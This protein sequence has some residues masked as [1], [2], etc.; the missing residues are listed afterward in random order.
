MVEGW[1]A[2]S[3]SQVPS[4]EVVFVPAAP[5]RISELLATVGE[6]PTGALVT[7]TDSDVVIDG[8]LP[9]EQAD[10]VE[11]RAEVVIDESALGINASGVVSSVAGRPGTDRSRRFSRL[12]RGRCEGPTTIPHRRLGAVDG[13]HQVDE[14]SGAH[15]SPQRGLARAGRGLPGPAILGRRIRNRVR[16]D[17][18]IG[19]WICQRAPARGHPEPGDLVLVGFDR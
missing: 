15:R 6:R 1:R 13:A 2:G 3:S 5:L 19:G 4:D 10:R 18:P 16:S 9:V 8:L 14:G 12:I 7:V 11:E 17:G